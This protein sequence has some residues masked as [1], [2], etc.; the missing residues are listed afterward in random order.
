M[1]RY[2]DRC[3]HTQTSGTHTD[4]DTDDEC[5]TCSL[6]AHCG[7]HEQRPNVQIRGS[8]HVAHFARGSFYA[9]MC[10]PVNCLPMQGELVSERWAHVCEWCLTV[11]SAI[12]VPP[13]SLPGADHP[14]A[15]RSVLESDLM[16]KLQLV[17]P[18]CS[19]ASYLQAPK[20]SYLAYPLRTSHERALLVSLAYLA[21][22][23]GN[24]L[25]SFLICVCMCV[26][27]SCVSVCVCVAPGAQIDLSQWQWTLPLLDTFMSV[28]PSLPE[29]RFYMLLET[30][31]LPIGLLNAMRERVPRDRVTVELS[32]SHLP[33]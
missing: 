23:P 16:K 20:C 15:L 5:K 13:R 33:W 30:D 31:K 3:T 21:F 8:T 4:T 11:K 18:A 12:I 25:M 7:P 32:I 22:T 28:Q 1:I 27:V 9:Y 24:V 6:R 2:E 17:S 14:A 10:V 19:S 29:H 26:C